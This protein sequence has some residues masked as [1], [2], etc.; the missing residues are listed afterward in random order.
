[1]EVRL[2]FCVT[3]KNNFLKMVIS[4][5]NLDLSEEFKKITSLKT[6]CNYNILAKYL[7]FYNY[8]RILKIFKYI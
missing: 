7:Q 6:D 3:L 4:S 8:F 1:M 2:M 5:S